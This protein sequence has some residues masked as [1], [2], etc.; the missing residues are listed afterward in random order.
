MRSCSEFTV[1]AC[2]LPLPAPLRRCII[3]VRFRGA[4]SRGTETA[5]Q[6]HRMG[7]CVHNRE[8]EP[9]KRSRSSRARRAGAGRG[10]HTY[11][12]E[13]GGGRHCQRSRS[14]DRPSRE[15]SAGSLSPP[16]HHTHRQ[17][18]V[19]DCAHK[20][21]SAQGDHA[22]MLWQ[23]LRRASSHAGTPQRS[24]ALV[25]S[26]HAQEARRRCRESASGHAHEGPRAD[27]TSRGG[28]AHA[29]LPRAGSQAPSLPRTEVL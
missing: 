11:E 7:T 16:E 4:V 15:G 6:M 20:R 9:C 18:G 12:R 14:G 23:R 27:Q 17:E 8:T 3:T 24:H 26:E 29:C 2:S 19:H 13:V 25:E 5:P 10:K 28:H 1:T 22:C 21:T